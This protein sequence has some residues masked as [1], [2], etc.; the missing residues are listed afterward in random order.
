MFYFIIIDMLERPGTLMTAY[1]ADRLNKKVRETNVERKN[2][3]EQNKKSYF[4]V[5]ESLLIYKHNR[6]IQ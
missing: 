6:F 1:S 3:V 2:N 4:H 5:R